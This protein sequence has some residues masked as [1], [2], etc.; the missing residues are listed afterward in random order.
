[1]RSGRDLDTGG[2]ETAGRGSVNENFGVPGVTSHLG[3]R[4]VSQGALVEPGADLS[5]DVFFDLHATDVRIVTLQTQHEIVLS[6]GER[7][8]HRSLAGL[9]GAV[10]E[11][12]GTRRIA[13]HVQ[14][15]G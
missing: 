10:N 8:G 4:D 2:G 12:V 1:M 15:L 9:L 3:P 7:K 6:G 11:Y 14:A 13:H 5:L